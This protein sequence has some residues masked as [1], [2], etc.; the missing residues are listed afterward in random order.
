MTA[1]YGKTGSAEYSTDKKRSHAWFTG[2]AGTEEPKIAVTVIVEDGGSGGE[3]A[4]PIA[5]NVFDAYFGR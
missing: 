5:K 4:V 3:V 1:A 2:F